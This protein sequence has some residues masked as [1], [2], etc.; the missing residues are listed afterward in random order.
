MK[1]K[2]AAK[3]IIKLAK[4]H[5]DWYTKQEVYY[6]KFIKKREKLKKNERKASER[7]PRRREDDGVHSKSEQ[8]KQ[9]VKSSSS[10]IA[11]LLY[12]AWSLVRV[13]AGSHDSRDRDN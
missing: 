2:K 6:A 1:D 9:P 11:R 7:D 4:K 10:R 13:R 3:K 12:K 8:S 5:P